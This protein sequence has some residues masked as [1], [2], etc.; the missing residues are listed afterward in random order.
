M[1]LFNT[2]LEWYNDVEL[3]HYI[4]YLIAIKKFNIGELYKKWIT[5]ESKSS[6]LNSLKKEIYDSLRN[7]VDESRKEKRSCRDILLFHNIQTSIQLNE[8]SPG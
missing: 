8:F 7:R 5:Q 1:E 6:F 4:G 3:Y 2:F